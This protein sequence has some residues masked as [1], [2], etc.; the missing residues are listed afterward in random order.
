VD[1][2]AEI[3]ASFLNF[4]R[5]EPL[6]AESRKPLRDFALGLAHWEFARWAPPAEALIKLCEVPYNEVRQF[7]AEALLAE[8]APQTR[9][10]RIDPDVLTPAAVYSFC[11]SPDEATRELGMKLIKRSPRL[12][13]PEELFRLTESPDRKVRAFVIRGLWSL[14]RDRGITVDWK[15]YLPPQPTTGAT[16][17]KRAAAAVEQLGLGAPHRPEQL[18]A[19][20]QSLAE[21]LRRILFEIPPAREDGAKPDPERLSQ[22]LK[23]LPARKAK[24]SL[25][26]VL[27]DL[28]LEDTAFA[29]GVLPLLEEFMASR[30]LS[31]R[32]ACLVAVTR[33]RATHP[34]LGRPSL[35]AGK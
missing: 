25:V 1:P 2:G 20:P 18:P 10:Y 14:Y 5:V 23:P 35:E 29:R 12:Q 34:E 6:F 7:V 26:E 30:G 17:A 8:D 28:A 3:P 16:A 11:E 19:D 22:R 4:E 24:L 21:F 33:I 9:R 32:A 27:R 31:E 13:L 15:P